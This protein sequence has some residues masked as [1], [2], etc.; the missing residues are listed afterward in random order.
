MGLGHAGA[1]AITLEIEQSRPILGQINFYSLH[2][3]VFEG[4]INGRADQDKRDYNYNSLYH[5]LPLPK[6]QAFRLFRSQAFSNSRP[7]S[8]KVKKPDFFTNYFAS[9]L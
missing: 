9:G 3:P 1:A 4:P 7:D 5:R 8:L 2:V 6:G